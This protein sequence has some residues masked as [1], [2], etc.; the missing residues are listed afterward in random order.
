MSALSGPEFV[1]L[2]KPALAVRVDFAALNPLP[3]VYT[4]WPTLDYSV[5]NA[6]ILGY[7]MKGSVTPAAV[8]RGRVDEDAVLDCQLRVIKPGAGD[9]KAKEARDAAKVLYQMVDNE[10]RS[11]HPDLAG[12]DNQVLWAR[13]ANY[14]LAQFPHNYGK[15]AVPSRVCVVDFEIHYKAR[16]AVD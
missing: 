16:L 14:E 7:D 4:A 9:A 13:C 12:A 8:G 6:I 15:P 11:N 3:V 10:L 2:L 1:D 5:F